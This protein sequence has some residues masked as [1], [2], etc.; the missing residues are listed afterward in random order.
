MIKKLAITINDDKAK[1]RW[2]LNERDSLQSNGIAFNNFLLGPVFRKNKSIYLI[3]KHERFMSLQ[4]ETDSFLSFWRGK[5]NNNY[6]WELL[7][8]WK[9]L[10]MNFTAFWQAFDNAVRN[11]LHIAQYTK[12]PEDAFNVNNNLLILWR[13]RAQK[14]GE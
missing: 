9:I 5:D 14:G 2:I 11:I 1:K 4:H 13:I 8:V 3:E 12:H 7:Q 6:K 10:A